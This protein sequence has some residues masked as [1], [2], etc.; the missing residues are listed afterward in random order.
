L[1]NMVTIALDDDV[2]APFSGE[3][4][5]AYKRAWMQFVEFSAEYDFEA[6]PP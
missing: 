2:F 4:P 1:Y 5:Q 3:S 6:G